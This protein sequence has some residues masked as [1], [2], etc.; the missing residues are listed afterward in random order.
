ML[1]SSMTGCRNK[2]MATHK[3]YSMSVSINETTLVGWGGRVPDHA[4]MKYYI[5]KKNLTQNHKPSVSNDVTTFPD[6]YF[7]LPAK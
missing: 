6:P 7:P 1:R 3:W 5:S 4:S 2:F